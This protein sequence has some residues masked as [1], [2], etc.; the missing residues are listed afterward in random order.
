METLDG[1]L[2]AAS[3]GAGCKKNIVR[4]IVHS[5]FRAATGMWSMESTPITAR[6][7]NFDSRCHGKTRLSIGWWNS[8]DS[9]TMLFGS[10]RLSLLAV[11]KQ[12]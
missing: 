11:W 12:V 4:Q 3:E 5:V 8:G 9:P 10:S 1:K 6:I 7:S 2:R